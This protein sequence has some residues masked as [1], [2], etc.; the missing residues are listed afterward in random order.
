M[1][2][3]LTQA[4]YL[5]AILNVL[6]DTKPLMRLQNM[7]RPRLAGS[8]FLNIQPYSVFADAAR[9]FKV[10]LAISLGL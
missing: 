10:N 5:Y 8:L 1:Y 3:I 4:V 9:M 2:A 6:N 7:E